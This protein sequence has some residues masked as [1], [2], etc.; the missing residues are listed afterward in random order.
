MAWDLIVSLEP[1]HLEK[2]AISKTAEPSGAPRL[3]LRSNGGFVIQKQRRDP[4]ALRS[5]LEFDG[6]FKSWAVARG[7]SLDPHERRLA[8][9]VEDHPLD[10]GI[11]KAPSQS[12]Y[13]GRHRAARRTA[14]IGSPT[15]PSADSGG[16]SE[17]SSCTATSFTVAGCLV[18]DPQR[19]RRWQR[20]N[21]LLIK[22]RDEF[23]R[24]ATPTT[25]GRR[26]IGGVGTDDAA[27]CRK[28]KEKRQSRS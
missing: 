6:V 9:E 14:A 7:P 11:S 2:S 22:H 18:A 19:P 21:W 5:A 28:A 27:D 1:L 8:V 13:G 12:Q 20:T 26:S 25:S 24:R 10:Y 4:A 23:A 17:N 16:R 15:I 3:R